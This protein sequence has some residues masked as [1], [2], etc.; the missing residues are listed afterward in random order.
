MRALDMRAS[1]DRRGTL[2]R[3]RYD[4]VVGDPTFGGSDPKNDAPQRFSW[5]T[6]SPDGGSIWD[7]R[8]QPAIRDPFLH[9][10]PPP[11]PRRSTPWLAIIAVTSTV[12]FVVA[13]GVAVWLWRSWVPAELSPAE[14]PSFDLPP[15]A[16]T[17]A[18]PSASVP[19]VRAPSPSVPSSVP[20]DLVPRTTKVT[21]VGKIAVVDVG[22]ETRK[23]LAEELAAQRSLALAEHQ[24]LVVMTTR[25]GIKE[26]LDV[27]AA[28]PHP[29]LQTALA[30][31]RLV[32]VDVVLFENE[33][34]E[35]GVPTHGIPWF[36]LIGP[37]LVPRDGI[38]G[39][40]WDDDIPRN[41]APVLGAF[42]HGNYK[43]RR[44]TWKPP[45]GK[46]VAL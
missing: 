16:P 5:S 27:D 30:D 38:D 10:P 22:V 3:A 12:L 6:G 23:T 33:L 45:K 43:A 41:I 35:L 28:L 1:V 42:V 25:F 36:V 29:L 7:T 2:A 26:F 19:V 20:L 15:V 4:A 21:R 24:T 39:G 8:G 9:A 17:A 13:G 34:E 14:S 11:P 40:E 18:P 46:G 31:V 37:D 44:Q 32:R